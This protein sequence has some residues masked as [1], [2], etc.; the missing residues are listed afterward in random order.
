MLWKQC[1]D[2][3][4]Y[5]SRWLALLRRCIGFSG[6]GGGGCH[7]ASMSRRRRDPRLHVD[8]QSAATR[9]RRGGRDLCAVSQFRAHAAESERAKA[10]NGG[11]W[12]RSPFLLLF[13]SA[14]TTAPHRTAAT[15]SSSVVPTTTYLSPHAPSLPPSIHLSINHTM[16]FL[17]DWFWSTLSFLGTRRAPLSSLAG[18]RR[19]PRSRCR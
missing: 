17:F 4:R 18:S 15:P 8:E 1:E 13:L 19:P 11:V 9:A 10:N 6:G 3:S 5:Q 7:E 16:S 14:T 12:L 2:L